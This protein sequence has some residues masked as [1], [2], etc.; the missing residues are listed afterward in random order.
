MPVTHSLVLASLTVLLAFRAY[1]QEFE[2][3]DVRVNQARR[4]SLRGIPAAVTGIVVSNVVTLP[5][6]PGGER[7]S[8]RRPDSATG[9]D[10]GSAMAA[11]A[12]TAVS[13]YK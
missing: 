7:A 3:A 13:T 4:T 2:V 8:T 5:I 11:I 6:K 10:V 1:G 12:F 9:L